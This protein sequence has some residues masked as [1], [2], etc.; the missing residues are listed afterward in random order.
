[1]IYID[2][3]CNKCGRSFTTPLRNSNYE[4]ASLREAAKKAGWVIN[5]QGDWCNT[6]AKINR[7]T[8]LATRKSE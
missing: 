1:M 2:L 4:M 7:E 5:K 6:C 3:R 8:R